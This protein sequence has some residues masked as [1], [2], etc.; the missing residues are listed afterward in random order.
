M[1]RFHSIALAALLPATLAGMVAPV[2]QAQ[3]QSQTPGAAAVNPKAAETLIKTLSDKA[4]A[5]L[6]DKSLGQA[7]REDRFRALL[8]EGFEL[9]FIGMSVLGVNRRTATPAQLSAFRQAFPD[10]VIRIYANRLT[11]Y[12]NTTLK[13]LG[14]QPVGTRGDVV[15]RT[16]VSGGSVSQPVQA[17]WRVRQFPGGAKIIDLSIAGVSMALTQRD[18]FNAKIQ[19][20]GL[21]TLIAEIKG[22]GRA[23]PTATAA[24]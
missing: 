21:D 4:F 5:V 19:A 8:R 9:D 1:K 23:G 7:Q 24:Q 11:D 13:V 2:A 14:S 10:Y 22:G 12:G 18:E 3:A 20:R 16:Q 6:R 15:V 17:D